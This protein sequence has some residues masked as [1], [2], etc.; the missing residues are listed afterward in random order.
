VSAVFVIEPTYVH[1]CLQSVTAARS[2]RW[3]SLSA[4]REESHDEAT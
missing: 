2:P 3:K 1:P 4:M